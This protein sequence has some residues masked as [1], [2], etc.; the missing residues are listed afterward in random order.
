MLKQIT[1]LE[2]WLLDNADE[3]VFRLWRY[4]KI[5][6]PLEQ[7]KK[8]IDQSVYEDS[9]CEFVYIAEAVEFPDGKVMFGFQNADALWGNDDN[10][11]EIPIEYL[12]WGDFKLEYHPADLERFKQE[13]RNEDGE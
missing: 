1:D 4:K 9:F 2:T 3:R 11:K 8:Y 5:F 13:Y 10:D 12:M 7:E 6:T